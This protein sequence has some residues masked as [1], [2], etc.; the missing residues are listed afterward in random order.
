MERRHFTR[1]V[2]NFLHAASRTVHL[3]GTCQKTQFYAFFSRLLP[4]ISVFL[5]TIQFRELL[6]LPC[7]AAVAAFRSSCKHFLSFGP[8]SQQLAGYLS[9]SAPAFSFLPPVQNIGSCRHLPLSLCVARGQW[10]SGALT[11][12]AQT[13]ASISTGTRSPIDRSPNGFFVPKGECVRDNP[14]NTSTCIA[15]S[16]GARLAKLQLYSRR[17]CSVRSSIVCFCKMVQCGRLFFKG[18]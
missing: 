11:R 8:V 2:S 1:G 10:R 4:A 16:C 17:R 14:Q 9:C 13:L 15:A 12:R 6:P 3:D 18:L 7:G 5:Y